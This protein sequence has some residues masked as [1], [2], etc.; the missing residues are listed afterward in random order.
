M[1]VG[2]FDRGAVREDGGRAEHEHEVQRARAGPLLHKTAGERTRVSKA[3]AAPARVHANSAI[4][5]RARARAAGL[6][7]AVSEPGWHES[8]WGNHI[9]LPDLS[10]RRDTGSEDNR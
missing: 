1:V 8:R 5:P 2:I 3:G 10:C 9:P 6:A 7:Q 4:T